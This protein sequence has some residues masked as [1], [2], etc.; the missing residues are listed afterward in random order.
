[1]YKTRKALSLSLE[2]YELKR[3]LGMS[4]RYFLYEPYEPKRTLDM[5]LMTHSLPP[6]Q[7]FEPEGILYLSLMSQTLHP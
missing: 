4:L 2:S 3:N 5:N 6:S 7:S 1:M